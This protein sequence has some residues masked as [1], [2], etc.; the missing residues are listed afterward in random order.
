MTLR[1]MVVYGTRP[2]AIK[3]APLVRQLHLAEDLAPYVV[4]TGQHREMLDQ[5]NSLFEISPDEDL[6]LMI[7]GASV[8][9]IARR[10]LEAMEKVL[11]VDQPDALVVQGD[12]TSALAA[13]LAGFLAEVPVVH[14][15]AGLRTGNLR[16]PFPEEA[17]RRLTSVVADLHLAPTSTARSNLEREG[18]DPESIVVTGNTVVDALHWAVHQPVEFSDPRLAVLGVDRGLVLV[19]THR[20]EAWGARMTDAMLGLRDIAG[21]HPE[22]DFLLPLHRNQ[23]VRDA[24]V[25]TLENLDNV[26]LTEPLAYA[27]F[28]HMMQR[29]HL[30]VTDSG[31][32]QEEAPSLGKPVLVLRDTTERPEGVE[33]GTVKLV[34]TDRDVVRDEAERLL[35]DP[36]AYAEMANAV[37]PYGDGHAA[38]RS[39]AAI[40]AILTGTAMPEEFH[41]V[42]R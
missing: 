24:V 41:P 18:I 42:A 12:T 25:G 29:A 34:G 32:V 1:V 19:T 14:V 9:A 35:V 16:S 39:V 37:N 36:T 23:V 28:S 6:D 10:V 30:V 5:V 3:L 22:L 20:R 15:E 40:R 11:E 8:N 4:V 38:E 2:E 13:S 31:G 33:A 21:Q 17:N 27:E 26:V 7:H